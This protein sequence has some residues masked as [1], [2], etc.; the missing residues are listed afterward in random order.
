M[1]FFE[2]D[3][4]AGIPPKH[5]Y[6]ATEETIY[7]VCWHICMFKHVTHVGKKLPLLSA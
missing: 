4:V 2:V 7:N 6:I 1:E 5:P 3:I